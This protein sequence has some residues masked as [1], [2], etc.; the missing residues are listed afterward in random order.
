MNYSACTLQSDAG[1]WGVFYLVQGDR[2]FEKWKSG[3]SENFI[4]KEDIEASCAD[5]SNSTFSFQVG[6]E[7]HY[8][9]IVK[10][11]DTK[12]STLAITF[13]FNR[14]LYSIANGTLLDECSVMLNDTSASDCHVDI[15]LHSKSTALLDLQTLIPDFVDWDA[16]IVV[17]VQ[18]GARAWLYVIIA[19]SSVAFV[20]L[21]VLVAV[22]V[23]WFCCRKRQRRKTTAQEREDSN[24]VR[25]NE[26]EDNG[27]YDSYSAKPE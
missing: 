15:P 16:N 26:E 23:Y 11:A 17:D 7:D 24:L 1:P 3:D 22:V 10:S 25:R 18:C 27:L 20:A 13:T 21:L 12:E 5:D 6:E 8:Y 9:M 14:L 4:V 2:N 19:F